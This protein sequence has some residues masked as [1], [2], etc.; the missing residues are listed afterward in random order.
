MINVEEKCILLEVNVILKLVW[1]MFV[2]ETFVQRG[3]VLDED[4]RDIL[5]KI[6]PKCHIHYILKKLPYL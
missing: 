4:K 6:P 2:E 1:D 5:G 3:N